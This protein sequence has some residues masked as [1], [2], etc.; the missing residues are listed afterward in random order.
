[1]ALKKQAITFPFAKGRNDK[2]SDKVT[3]IGELVEAKNVSFDKAGQLT[4]RG[5]YVKQSNTIAFS[6]NYHDPVGSLNDASYATA[7]ND[8]ILIASDTQLFS[9]SSSGLAEHYVNRGDLVANEVT[10]SFLLRNENFKH[11]PVQTGCVY[12]GSV[13]CFTLCA[14]VRW[15]IPTG[16]SNTDTYIVIAEVRDA[17]TNQLLFSKVLGSWTKD[18]ASDWAQY[19]VPDP[20]VC[21]LGEKAFVIWAEPVTAYA[22]AGTAATKLR[23]A[24]V[25]LGVPP[26]AQQTIVFGTI[27]DLPGFTISNHRPIFDVDVVLAEGNS[28]V[29]GE[30][31]D[32]AIIVGGLTHSNLNAQT[33]TATCTVASGSYSVTVASDKIHDILVGDIVT[34]THISG[35]ATYVT[36]VNQNANTFAMNN[37]GTGPGSVTLT[38]SRG[39]NETATN[40]KLKFEYFKNSSTTVLAQFG[41]PAVTTALTVGNNGLG[42]SGNCEALP[43]IGAP[44]D[45]AIAPGFAIKSIHGGEAS[46]GQIFYAVSNYVTS[47][48]QIRQKYGLIAHGLGSEITGLYTTRGYLLRATAHEYHV[49]NVLVVA[50]IVEDPATGGSKTN[51]RSANHKIISF[52]M[53]RGGSA[54]GTMPNVQTVAYESSM[55]SDVFRHAGIAYFVMSHTNGGNGSLSGNMLLMREPPSG[56]AS[57]RKWQI[58]GAIETGNN[59]ANFTSDHQSTI[60]NKL[61]MFTKQSRVQSFPGSVYK[62]GSNRFSTLIEYD[63]HADSSGDASKWYKDESH[64]PSIASINFD[65]DR[66]HKS[67][68][69]PNGMLLTG[70]FL[71][72]YDGSNLHENNFFV[73]PSF[74]LSKSDTGGALDNGAYLYRVVYEWYDDMGN[75][76]RSAPSASKSCTVGGSNVGKTTLSIQALQITRKRH[77]L[78]VAVATAYA[79][80]ANGVNA[81]VYR[82]DASGS[83]YY[84]IGGIELSDKEENR[85]VTFYDSGGTSPTEIADNELLYAQGGL[86]SNGFIGSCKDIANHK[87]RT[88]VTTSENAVRYSKHLLGRDGINFPDSHFIR[89]GSELV[90]VNAIESSREAF[91]LFT[92]KDGYYVGGDGPDNSGVGSFTQPRVFA[93]GVGAFAASDHAY[94]NSGTMIQTSRGIINVLPNLQL[95]YISANVEDTLLTTGVHSICA[96]EGANEIRFFL[97]DIASSSSMKVLVYHTLYQQWTTHEIAYDSSAYGSSAFL[98]TPTGG[99]G[100]VLYLV[101]ADGNLHKYTPKSYQDT[102]KS[103][104]AV[105]YDM[106]VE[107]GYLTLAGFQGTQRAYRF[108]LLGDYVSA[109]T[110]TVNI[111]KD[112]DDN[113][114]TEYTSSIT[115]DA[116]PYHYR[117]H[118]TNQR[119]LAVKA[120]IT[121]SGASLEGVK[122]DGIAFEVGVRTTPFKLPETQTIGAS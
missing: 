75:I 73:F 2:G 10:N 115:S 117:G 81:T 42:S 104:G 52:E 57:G 87:E 77:G 45:Q 44:S 8:E 84:K 121:I 112:Y 28:T 89:V 71:H 29:A 21:V 12:S 109:H 88:F 59:P 98:M 108:M 68:T 106:V 34:G 48:T 16:A 22:T 114:S 40:G 1:M 78:S 94:T 107:T 37:A 116:N 14:Y 101:T 110:L 102:N 30:S 39:A 35:S 63:A 64:S 7:Y 23:Y 3:P 85:T 15:E 120:R 69:T 92:G 105:N 91:L 32:S 49:G 58:I 9:R 41:T 60:D 103:S 24:G 11:G 61:R 38:F 46:A 27:A 31:V 72:H 93:P 122:L 74:T 6:G 56:G 82:T 51:R 4:K 67:L 118:L 90:D 79:S 70:G 36:S 19:K 50:E 55:V 18:Y 80:S 54:T 43:E 66:K 26:S 62:F 83:I 20:R 65:P 99:T 119:C 96:D 86:E 53:A 97:K 25:S 100:L 5:A 17:I 76:H 111:F 13:P 113:S 95:D 47:G 33:F